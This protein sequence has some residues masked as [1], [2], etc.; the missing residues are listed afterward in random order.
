MSTEKKYLVKANCPISCNSLFIP[1][2]E[3]AVVPESFVKAVGDDVTVIEE[4]QDGEVETETATDEG[5]GE[6][7]TD[8]GKSTDEGDET[9]DEKELSKMNKKELMQAA[10][11]LGIDAV[12]AEAATK[13]ELVLLIEEKAK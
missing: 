4:V 2:G 8:D 3:T 6:G 9:D 1:K 7:T 13:K 5:A 12:I 11:D 10:I